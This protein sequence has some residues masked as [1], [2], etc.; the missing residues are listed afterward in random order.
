MLVLHHLNH[1][2]S[3]RIIWLLEE[4]KVEYEIKIYKR[5][6]SGRAPQELKDVQQLGKSPVVTDDGLTIIESGAIIDY[7]VTKYGKGKFVPVAG[8]E[9]YVRYSQ[10]L[11]FAE[12]T[13][14][15]PLIV[16]L[17]FDKVEQNSPWFIRPI[18][19]GI[20]SKV[21]ETYINPEVTNDLK[22]IESHLSQFKWFAGGDDITGAD[23]QMSFPLEALAAKG[24]ITEASYPSIWKWLEVIKNRPD[25]AKALEKGGPYAYALKPTEAAAPVEVAAVE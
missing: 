18:A 6:S 20:A 5:T 3:Q 10:W 16:T 2:R 7:L 11:H 24:T 25:Y 12:G 19:S 8:T 1:S 21:R 22:Y 17:I 23:F 9:E 4:L 15:T 14:M 13:I